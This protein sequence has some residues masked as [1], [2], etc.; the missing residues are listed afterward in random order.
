MPAFQMSENA[1]DF[2]AK[3]RQFLHPK[4]GP[5]GRVFAP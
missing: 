2:R 4:M 3:I 1:Q 5:F